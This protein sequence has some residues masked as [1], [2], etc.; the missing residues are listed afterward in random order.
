[1]MHAN[2]SGVRFYEDDQSLARIVAEFLGAGFDAGS[3]AVVLVTPGQR[4]AIVRELLRRRIDA[5]ALQQSHD[6]LFL[7]AEEQLS[8]F[9]I[10]GSVDAAR[11][12]EQ[13]RDA[14]QRVRR[15]RTDR[16]VRLFGQI[17]DVLWR[18]EKRDAAIQLEVLWNQLARTEGPS[19]LS[20]YAVGHFYK[21]A[22]LATAGDWV[23]RACPRC[24]SAPT[25]KRVRADATTV[26]CS[27]CGC[28]WTVCRMPLDAEAFEILARAR[29]G[30]IDA[31]KPLVP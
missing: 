8:A 4:T 27:T 14:I 2:W 12:S 16:T 6:L 19:L 15:G 10:D 17:V 28:E 5:L 7:D 9:M 18:Q 20:G 13:M 22:N 3:P 11:F 25:V 23:S 31:P 21:D 1:M 30:Q 29:K 26:M 24:K